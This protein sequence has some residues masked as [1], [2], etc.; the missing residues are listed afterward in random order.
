MA[1]RGFSFWRT[2][3]WLF[4]AAAV[5]MAVV[6]AVSLVVALSHLPGDLLVTVDGERVDLHALQAGHWFLAI[7]GVVLATLIVLL[8]V[9]LA[10]LLGVGLPLL[11]AGLGLVAALLAMALVL[12]LV[13]SPLILLGLLVWWAA[14]PH[15][16]VGPAAPALPP[17]VPVVG[18]HTDNATPFA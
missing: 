14:R 18:Q 6:T 12:G 15:R 16:P 17:A 8:V 1:T 7:G 10:L 9:P 4:L 13:G 11:L 5:V 3:G 2:L